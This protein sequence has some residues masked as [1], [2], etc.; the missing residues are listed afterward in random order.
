MWDSNGSLEARKKSCAC[1]NNVRHQN[2]LITSAQNA[3]TRY[4]DV[5]MLLLYFLKE[6]IGWI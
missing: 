4:A 6:V 5:K 2:I 3:M 1:N